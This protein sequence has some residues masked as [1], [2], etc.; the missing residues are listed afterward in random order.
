MVRLVGAIV[1]RPNLAELANNKHY[2]CD[3][4]GTCAGLPAGPPAKLAVCG[5]AKWL[6]SG[7]ADAVL[8]VA[9]D[10]AAAI[11]FNGHPG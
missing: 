7:T 1:I 6:R 10:R 2:V 5:G 3:P 11:R 8:N 4:G 9:L